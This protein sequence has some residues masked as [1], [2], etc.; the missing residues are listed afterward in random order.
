M[1]FETNMKLNLHSA[2]NTL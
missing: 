1:M 2:R